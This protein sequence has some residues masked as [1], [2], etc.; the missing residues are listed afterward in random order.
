[1][2]VVLEPRLA[3]VVRTELDGEPLVVLPGELTDEVLDMARALLS[4]DELR[5]V[6]A[7]VAQR[8]Q[9]GTGPRVPW[10]RG[11]RDDAAELL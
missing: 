8:V 9:T 1:M 6:L 3:A 10:P 11:Q 7:A 4:A 2:V 5:E